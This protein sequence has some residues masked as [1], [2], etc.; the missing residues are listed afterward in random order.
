M[1]S[2]DPAVGLGGFEGMISWYNSRSRETLG[3]LPAP[4][5]LINSDYSPTNMEAGREYVPSSDVVFMSGVGHFVMMEDP[6]TFNGLL[7][8]AISNS[9][10]AAQPTG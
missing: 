5:L 6:D 2:A 8:E 10:S 4:L 3:A 7:D 1:S 9:L